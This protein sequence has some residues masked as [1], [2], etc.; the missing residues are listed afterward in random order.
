ML[1]CSK[2]EANPKFRQ[3]TIHSGK[4]HQCS[5]NTI[6]VRNRRCSEREPSKKYQYQYSKNLGVNSPSKYTE[7]PYTRTGG[8]MGGGKEGR[9]GVKEK[10]ETKGV[11]EC[12][13]GRKEGAVSRKDGCQGKKGEGKEERMDGR[14]EGGEQ[15]R[16]QG[17]Q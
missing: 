13:E 10:A 8:W 1:V 15:G 7:S 2:A 14:K 4:K 17:K 11:K 6:P 16:K 9:K 12:K 3:S 5:K